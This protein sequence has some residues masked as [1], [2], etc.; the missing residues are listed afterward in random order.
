MLESISSR[1]KSEWN[2]FFPGSND[3]GTES[4]YYTGI[5]GSAIGGT[6]SFIGFSSKQK[7]PL[8]VVKVF[9]DSHSGSKSRMEN[10]VRVLRILA[11]AGLMG[12]IPRVIDCGEIED[13][14]YLV[15]SYLPGKPFQLA[16]DG[17]G[18]P[19]LGAFGIHIE[20]AFSWVFPKKRG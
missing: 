18:N 7:K 8:F 20:K 10:E 13:C 1:L 15:Q 11:H 9:R 17:R 19:R 5:T 2:S 16:L 12:T 6:T 14:I 3:P 4:I